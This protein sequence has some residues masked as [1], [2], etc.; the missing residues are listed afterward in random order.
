MIIVEKNIFNEKDES[1]NSKYKG[2]HILDKE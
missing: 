2:L 1:H